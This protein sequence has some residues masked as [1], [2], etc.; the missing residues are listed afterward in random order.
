MNSKISSLSDH[1]IL[2]GYGR[3]GGYIAAELKQ[4]S[5]QVVVIEKNPDAIKDLTEDLV[6]VPDATEDSVLKSAGVERA[7]S[8]ICAQDSGAANVCITHTAKE[9]NSNI[10]ITARSE[11]DSMDQKLLRAGAERVVSPFRT[12]AQRM[13]ITTLQPN[14]VDL[15]VMG[16]DDADH[17]ALRLEEVVVTGGPAD[18]L[19][20][21]AEAA[22]G[23]VE[24]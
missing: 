17:R 5:A 21:V 11:S 3:V 6:V 15:M 20:R 4:R 10:Q 7:K 2:C 23:M 9:F 14:A 12:G 8:L 13:A 1:I 19:E 16:T 22:A 24:A 18:K